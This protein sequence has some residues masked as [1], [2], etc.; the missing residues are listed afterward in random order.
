MYEVLRFMLEVMELKEHPAAFRLIMENP[1]SG[2]ENLNILYQ[3]VASPNMATTEQYDEYIT[4]MVN[5]MFPNLG[6][7]AGT[8]HLHYDWELKTVE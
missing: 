7:S 2:Y 1:E 5:N 3:R 8:D 4:D 6:C